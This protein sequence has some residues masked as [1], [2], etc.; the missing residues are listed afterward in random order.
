MNVLI[1]GGGGREHA[2]AWAV[3]R[4]PSCGDLWVARGNAGTARI[5]RNVDLR[6]TDAAAIASLCRRESIDLVVV[7]P[8][9]P[10]V[11]GVADALRADGTAVF[12]PGAAGARL[13]GSKAHAKEVM[14]AAGIPTARGA[15]VGSVTEAAK[16]LSWVGERVAVKADGLAAGKGVV[17]APDR[18]TAIAA[19][20][21]A[22]E[23]RVFG[24]AGARVVLEEWLEGEEVSIIALVDGDEV[25][26]LVPSQDHKRAYDGDE[27]PNTGGMGAYAPYP[28]LDAT[29]VE[30][31]AET[32]LRP[33]VRELARR[34]T[35]FRGVLYA[36]LML[37]ADGPRVL[38]YN[39]RFGDPETQVLL[40]MLASDALELFAATAR[41]ELARC[42]PLRFRPGAALTV[43]AAAA[44][45]PAGSARG[46]VISGL[47]G[48][49]D[50][51][52]ALVFQ[53]G[54][55]VGDGGRPETN[56]GRVL[57]VTGLGP[58]LAAARDRA[59]EALADIS[60]PGMRWRTDI[61]HRGLGARVA[62]REE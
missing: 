53:A 6:E 27:G 18:E 13:E 21:A 23:D 46:D 38:E 44:D 19:V 2:I 26:P 4:S 15:T 52:D 5:A 8:E 22:V 33:L 58:S 50:R 40:P 55:R 29:A 57:A 41:G 32:C 43:V 30:S 7:G 34:G 59:Y 14:E 37:T 11:A 49:D 10:L 3:S 36:G 31:V 54:T 51:G 60:F 56:G 39:V 9:A 61:G 16:A 48:P 47:E 62:A 35:P 1:I 20:K 28:G 12:G 45:Y 42:E 24:D 25:R 17:M